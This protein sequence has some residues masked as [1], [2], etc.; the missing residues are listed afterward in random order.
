MGTASRTAGAKPLQSKLQTL[1]ILPQKIFV[2][3]KSYT[4]PYDS[5]R[6][7]CNSPLKFDLITNIPIL[8]T[9]RYYEFALQA[10][11]LRKSKLR[12]VLMA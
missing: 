6:I 1:I 5:L 4:S 2:R 10:Y 9:Y 12:P 8:N 7:P 3:N 11:P